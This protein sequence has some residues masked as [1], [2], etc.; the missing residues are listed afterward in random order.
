M[1]DCR[2]MK[3]GTQMKSVGRSLP[4]MVYAYDAA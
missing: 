4:T 3:W 1:G 2:G